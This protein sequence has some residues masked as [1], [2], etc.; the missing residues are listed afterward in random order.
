MKLKERIKKHLWYYLSFVVI[1]IL[2]FFW[3]MLSG[4][5][6]QAQTIALFSTTALYIVW[7]LTHQY[8]HHHLSTK[9]VVEYI[10][11][12]SLGLTFSLLLFN[13]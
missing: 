6:T 12:G 10:L 13:I 8:I 1:Q 5:Q 11:I 4:A 9:V 7:S 2:G 3:V